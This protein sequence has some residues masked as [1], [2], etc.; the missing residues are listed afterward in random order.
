MVS[1]SSRLVSCQ[2]CVGALKR[3]LGKL[4]ANNLYK[5]RILEGRPSM[6]KS[7]IDF[8]ECM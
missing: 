7:Q 8:S 6:E 5:D 1:Q 3:V 2:G 4:E